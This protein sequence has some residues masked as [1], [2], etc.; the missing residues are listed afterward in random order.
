MLAF[1]LP[2]L[3]WE[4]YDSHGGAVEDALTFELILILTRVDH[5]KTKLFNPKLIDYGQSGRRPDIYLNT[6]V[7]AYIECVRTKGHTET[8]VKSLEEHIN[9][10]IGLDAVAK[11]YDIGDRDFAILNYQV[12]GTKPLVPTNPRL[13]G[14]IFAKHV[15]T[16]TMVDKHLYRG[17]MLVC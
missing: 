2:K 11:R 14:K 6:S 13:S 5:L 17:S 4:Q 10:F 15:F 7:D 1:A 9:R 8:D 16:F 3:C 12:E